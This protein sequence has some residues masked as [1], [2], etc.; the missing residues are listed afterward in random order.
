MGRRAA[1]PGDTVLP[2]ER[3]TGWGRGQ[4]GVRVRTS[5]CAQTSRLRDDDQNGG[6][7]RLA[8]GGQRPARP[9]GAFVGPFRAQARP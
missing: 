7:G 6:L 8:C 3:W 1:V 4:N 2:V 5:A 9:P